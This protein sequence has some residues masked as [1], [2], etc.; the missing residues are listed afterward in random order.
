MPLAATLADYIRAAFSGI[1]IETFEPDEA[2]REIQSLCRQE[3]WHLASWD[4]DRGLSITGQ[5]SG[6]ATVND[7]LAA[8]H[9][10]PAMATS[11]GTAVLVLK[12][13]QRFLNSA[14]IIQSLQN[15][16]LAGKAT[17]TFCVILAPTIQL[18][19]ELER[20]F[21]VL[22]HDLPNHEQLSVI[23]HEI[24]ADDQD[25]VPTGQQLNALLDSAAGL[26]RQEAE[27]AFALSL[28]R[29]GELRSDAIWEIKAQSLRKQNLLSLSRGGENFSQLGGMGS[30][31]D[32]CRRALR[33]GSRLK[34]RG[35]LLLSPPG[36]GKSQ[37]CKALGNE[38]GRPVLSLD[39][40]KVMSSLVGESERN[41]RQALQIAEA[42][43]PSILFVDELEK[44]LSGVNGSGD[45]G[46]STRLFGTILTWLA[47]HDSD[48]FF[49][50]TANDIRRLPPEF[51]RAE[52]LDGVFFVDLP[53][54]Q[55][56]QSIWKI[57]CTIYDI[58]VKEPIPPDEGF[59]GAEIKST[60]RLSALL[61]ITLAEAAQNVVPVSITAGE[62]IDQLRTWANGRCLSADQP[63]VYRKEAAVE[64]RRRIS[65]K[66]SKN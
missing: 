17:R 41:I 7:P 26:T 21:V 5:D 63:G 59:T 13:F 24:L 44:G 3:N 22:H 51:T 66:I 39:I 47:D 10:L 25:G 52:R 37:F 30:L 11:N 38:V 50:G 48:V 42:M 55:Q 18:P 1:Y 9:S 23:A 49:I 53:T 64:T 32:F 61:G 12:N 36:C 65:S 20:Q 57:Y 33:P 56:R 31:K 15:Q 27:G 28:A 34:A 35:V 4:V 8:I 6:V 43:A 29:H 16:L 60:C 54:T 62:S 58:D 2:F 14:E 40:G 45:S 19:P 46:V